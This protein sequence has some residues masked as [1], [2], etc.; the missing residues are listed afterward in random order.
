MAA[1][2]RCLADPTT[3]D[4]HRTP[5]HPEPA[6]QEQAEHRAGSD[7]NS[8]EKTKKEDTQS[9]GNIV[10]SPGSSGEIT[11]VILTVVRWPHKSPKSTPVHERECLELA[12]MRT[13]LPR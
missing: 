2:R 10:W 3:D 12:R 4:D 7:C 9:H 8:L 1:R 11:M 13:L 6:D 5:R